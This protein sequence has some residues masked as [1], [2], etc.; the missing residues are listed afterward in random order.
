MEGRGVE[1]H[2][3]VTL[4]NI[5]LHP[6]RQ[7]RGLIK[8]TE[9]PSAWCQSVCYLKAGTYCVAYYPSAN[10]FELYNSTDYN[11]CYANTPTCVPAHEQWWR[12]DWVRCPLLTHTFSLHCRRHPD[13]QCLYRKKTWQDSY[14]C[15]VTS[16]TCS[17]GNLFSNIFILALGTYPPWCI[18]LNFSAVFCVCVCARV[19]SFIVNDYLT[20]LW[21]WKQDRHK[22]IK[23][24]KSILCVYDL[25]GRHTDECV[26]YFLMEKKRFVWNPVK[27]LFIDLFTYLRNCVWDKE[28]TIN[29]NSKQL[30]K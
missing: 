8:Y 1:I 27:H 13:K 11:I 6:C 10:C 3:H 2:S 29:S 19:C 23:W 22:N 30:D 5:I 20:Y 26:C 17:N 24:K 9:P 25:F 14:I 12:P 18:K 16:C 7:G 4:I 15:D 21:R 28:I